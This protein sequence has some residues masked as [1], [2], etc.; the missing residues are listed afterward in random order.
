VGL[1]APAIKATIARL[2]NRTTGSSIC[3]RLILALLRLVVEPSAM[4]TSARF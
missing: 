1:E 3:N 4:P 2:G